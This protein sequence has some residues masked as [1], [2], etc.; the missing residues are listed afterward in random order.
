MKINHKGTLA[1]LNQPAGVGPIASYIGR[2]AKFLASEGYVALTI[3]AKLSLVADLS[4][5][6]KR[7]GLSLVDL[8]EQTL[9]QFYNHC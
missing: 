1:A 5:W 2:F 9:E 8:D 7:H 4:C 3:N 6:L